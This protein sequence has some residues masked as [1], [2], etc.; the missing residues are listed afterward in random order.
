[1]IDY[2]LPFENM[3]AYETSRNELFHS[4]PD[5]IS[6]GKR[7]AIYCQTEFNHK[8]EFEIESVS[9]LSSTAHT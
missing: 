5:H 3:V 9:V 4:Y 6:K 7:V 1:M 2:E 8:T